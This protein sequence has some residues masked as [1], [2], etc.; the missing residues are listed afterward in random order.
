MRITPD[1]GRPRLNPGELM[2]P[3]SYRAFYRATVG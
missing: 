1:P 3:T 2:D